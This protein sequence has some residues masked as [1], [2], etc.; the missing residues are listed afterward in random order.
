MEEVY[1]EFDSLLDQLGYEPTKVS[2][3]FRLRRQLSLEGFSSCQSP[4][5]LL[6]PNLTITF[7]G[8]CYMI[9]ASGQADLSRSYSAHLQGGKPDL[10][11]AEMLQVTSSEEQAWSAAFG[12]NLCF[13]RYEC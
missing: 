9:R 5:F 6:L 11:G 4:L 12:F 2:H 1:E 10:M 3:C 8:Y 7:A 13:A